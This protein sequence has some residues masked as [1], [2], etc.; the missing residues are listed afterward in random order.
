MATPPT[1][2][3]TYQNI[4]LEWRPELCTHCG[5]CK[6]GL[7]LVFNPDRRPWVDLTM[8]SEEMIVGQVDECPS[9]AISINAGKL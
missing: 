6:N 9:G 2:T 1:R 3:Y 4:V 8:A 5:N 7:P